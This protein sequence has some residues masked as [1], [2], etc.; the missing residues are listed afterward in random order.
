[1]SAFIRRKLVSRPL[2]ERVAARIIPDNIS[3]GSEHGGEADDESLSELFYGFL[4]DDG[5]VPDRSSADDSDSERD[6]VMYDL[7]GAIHDLSVPIVRCGSDSFRNMI[8]THVIKAMEIF[9]FVKSNG[10][11]LRRN[12]MAY[13]RNLGYNAAICKT[14]WENSGGLSAGNYEFIDVVRSDSGNRLTRYFI[15]LEFAAEFEIARPTDQYERLL[16]SLPNV[17][18]GKIEELKQILKVISDAARRSLKSR[19][20]HLPP[21]RKHRY[22]QN[23]WFGPF[24]RTTNLFPATSSSSS[25]SKQNFPVKCRSIGFDTNAVNGRLLF[26]A[27]ARTR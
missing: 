20:L 19:D 18:V 23:K 21:W 16:Q 2:D 3:S 4:A 5:A 15:D 10:P 9:S 22:M 24:K 1:M 27:T 17:F 26:P 7:A 13:L 14:K 6:P 11:L 12:V 8:L 25:S